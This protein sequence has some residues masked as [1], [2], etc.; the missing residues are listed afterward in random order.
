MA[1]PSYQ[2]RWAEGCRRVGVGLAHI[3]YDVRALHR[4]RMP[5]KVRSSSSRTTWG[6]WT[7]RWSSSSVPGCC[8]SS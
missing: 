2:P 3:L 5:T 4:D 6:S 8:A 7:D 1:I